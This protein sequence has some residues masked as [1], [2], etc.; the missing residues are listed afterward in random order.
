MLAKGEAVPIKRSIKRAAPPEFRTS[1]TKPTRAHSHHLL[2]FGSSRAAHTRRQ[3]PARLRVVSRSP[4]PS[5]RGGDGT[6]RGTAACT[7]FRPTG[8]A[9]ASRP[10]AARGRRQASLSISRRQSPWSTPDV[11]EVCTLLRSFA[12]RR[13]HGGHRCATAGSGCR[14]VMTQVCVVEGCSVDVCSN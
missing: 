9:R 14:A 2:R 12:R 5:G 8:L 10:R 3:D 13:W 1:D 6:A 4:C 7:R 11:T